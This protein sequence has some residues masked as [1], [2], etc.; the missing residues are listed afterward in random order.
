MAK[1][2]SGTGTTGKVKDQFA[3]TAT[4]AAPDGT[5]GA[6]YYDSD[7]NALMSYDTAWTKIHDT[8][9]EI[10]FL[11]VGGGGGGAFHHALALELAEPLG[12]EPIG[13]PGD[14]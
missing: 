5:M 3:P 6:V 10:E 12:E 1:L 14:S 9:Y 7:K 8:G 11:C 2:K 13:E 4:A